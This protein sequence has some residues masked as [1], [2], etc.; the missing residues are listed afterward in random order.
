MDVTLVTAAWEGIKFAK[1]A[2]KAALDYKIEIEV[3]QKIVAALEKLGSTQ[4]DLFTVRENLFRLQEENEK[5]RQQLKARDEWETQKAGY[6]LEETAGGAVVY[7]ST[8]KEVPKHYA[9]PS[10]YTKE[11]IQILQDR[12]VVSG[13]FDCSGC[14]AGYYVKA[15]KPITVER[16]PKEPRG[17]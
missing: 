2:L 13:I 7:S 16:F 5:L 15:R 14:K 8:D 9:C 12:G 1:D 17:F 6:R 11:T 10:C 4:D 3:R